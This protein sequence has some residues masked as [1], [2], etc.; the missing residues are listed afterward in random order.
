[1]LSALPDD[2]L[3][4][5]VNHKE[6]KHG[7]LTEVDTF[8]IAFALSA[9]D[10]RLRKFVYHCYLPSVTFVNVS[11]LDPDAFLTPATFQVIARSP[12]LHTFI[13]VYAHLYHEGSIRTLLGSSLKKLVLHGCTGVS[14]TTF[15][16]SD[17]S[18]QAHIGLSYLDLSY[19]H[20]VDTDV[21]RH[22]SRLPSLHTL[23]LRGCAKVDDCAV[24]TLLQGPPRNCLQVLNLAYC[25]VSDYA[26]HSLLTN[27]ICLKQLSL[28]ESSGN[29]W[30]T[31]AYTQQGV[32]VLQSQFKHV[33]FSFIV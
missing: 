20:S 7:H 17:D 15:D 13:V 32:R 26:L 8:R 14:A 33:Q 12:R 21:L 1:M 16:I 23:I 24:Q 3:M 4:R 25:P 30:A 18:S 28:A 31:G 6:E 27:L 11:H 9:V 5:I 10:R 22:V 29:L 2:L 19:V